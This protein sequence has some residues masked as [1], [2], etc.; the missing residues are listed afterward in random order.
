M[1]IKGQN[2]YVNREGQRRIFSQ[3]VNVFY[4]QKITAPR[5]YRATIADKSERNGAAIYFRDST[6]TIRKAGA[7]IHLKLTCKMEHGEMKKGLRSA[8]AK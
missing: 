2:V 7:A 5:K 3:H 1:G 4:H 6:V 8:H